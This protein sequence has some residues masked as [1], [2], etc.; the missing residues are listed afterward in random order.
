MT[1]NE[2]TQNIAFLQRSRI[3]L[4]GEYN[5]LLSKLSFIT[6]YIHNKILVLIKPRI[7]YTISETR[8]AE[9]VC[10]PI[11]S[12]LYYPAILFIALF[13]LLTYP[14]HATRC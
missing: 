10:M 2:E 8:T 1:F 9:L 4:R 7:I 14:R 12:E 11:V 3:P 13:Q 6:F 5:Y